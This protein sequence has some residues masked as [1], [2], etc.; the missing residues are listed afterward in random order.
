MSD[1]SITGRLDQQPANSAPRYTYSAA[2]H[3]DL[4]DVKARSQLRIIWDGLKRDSFAIAGLVII[5]MTIFLA[6][7][8]PY[9]APHD[10]LAQDSAI[11]LSPIGTS[12][13]LLG[14][15]GN[16][17]DILSRLIYGSRTALMIA[18]V[19]VVVACFFGLLMGLAAGI[20]AAG[21]IQS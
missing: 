15:D 3:F 1:S 2:N 20:S 4:R 10:P 5:L 11:R 19:P 17:G 18:V 12:G 7:F 6:V 14:T 16:G 21:S 8:A 9:V 13:H